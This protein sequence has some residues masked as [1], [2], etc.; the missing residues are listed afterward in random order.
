MIGLY[1]Y[2]EKCYVNMERVHVENI[3]KMGQFVSVPLTGFGTHAHSFKVLKKRGDSISVLVFL[4][5]AV[6]LVHPVGMC[7]QG[8]TQMVILRRPPPASTATGSDYLIT[9]MEVFSEHRKYFRQENYEKV[10]LFESSHL[11]QME[12][13]GLKFYR[14]IEGYERRAGVYLMDPPSNLA[15]FERAHEHDLAV[16]NYVDGQGYIDVTSALY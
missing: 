14:E 4:E 9:S 2:L 5:D 11:Q 8:G 12:C 13:L 3:Q 6:K 1:S 16:N 15:D 10:S 7:Y